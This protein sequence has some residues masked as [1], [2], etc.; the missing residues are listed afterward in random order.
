VSRLREVGNL[1]A[2][3]LIVTKQMKD[4]MGIER[5]IANI[6]L[7]EHTFTAASTHITDLPPGAILQ[8]R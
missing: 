4:S 8:S 7:L 2:E 3:G 1:C 5:T 6:E